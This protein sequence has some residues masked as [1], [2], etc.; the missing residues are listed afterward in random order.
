MLIAPIPTNEVQRLESLSQY[1]LLDTAPEIEY[2]RVSHIAS[3]L[4]QT[5]IA[6]VSLIDRDRQWVKS[7]YGLAVSVIPREVSLCAHTIINEQPLIVEDTTKDIRFWDNPAVTGQPYILFYAGIPLLSATGLPIGSLCVIDHQPRQLAA[8][9]QL[10][11][12]ALA[13]QVMLLMELRRTN[14]QLR[15]ARTDAVE[16]AHQKAHLLATLSH[17][18]RTPLHALEGYTQLLLDEEPHL[19]Q[20]NS[21]L[22]LQT[23]G[24]TLV[25]LVNNILDY[26]KLQAGKLL[27]ESIPFS[28]QELIQQA[29]EMQAWQAKQKKLD[30][31]SEIDTRLPAR[32]EGDATRLLQVLLNLVSNALKFT[33]SG[34]VSVQAKLVSATPEAVTVKMEVSDTG[35]GIPQSSLASLFNEYTQVSAATTRLYGG[36]GLGLAI[37]RQ[38]LELMGSTLE[39]NSQEGRGSTFGFSLTLPIVEVATKRL[40]GL[41]R[42]DELLMAVD[43]N[44]MNTKILSHLI[45]RYGGQVAVFNSPLEALESARNTPYKGILLDLY[46]PEMDG[47]ELAERLQEIQP[48]VPLIALSADDSSETIERVKATGFRFFLRKPFLPD[49]LIHMLTKFI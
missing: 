21:V 20:Q 33:Q 28:L 15:K 23:T 27:L 18:I 40:S 19:N 1:N 12:Q 32:L 9:Q 22:R 31:V 3:Q 47:Y 37:T 17:E 42:S 46:M 11:L 8:S 49:E 6:M 44:P 4:C 35:I 45:S 10:A 29:L 41:L 14:D 26:S 36:S 30:L 5:P 7:F 38:L 48:D 43:D 25:S 2:D 34:K 13:D 16:L 24:R 39:V